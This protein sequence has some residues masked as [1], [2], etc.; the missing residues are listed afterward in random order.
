MIPFR[1]I[2]KTPRRVYYVRR[3]DGHDGIETGYVDRQALEETGVVV[4]RG[5]SVGEYDHC[6]FA[7]RARAEAFLDRH[8]PPRPAA[9]D[10]RQLRREMAD[11]HPDRGGTAEEFM[12]ARERYERAQWRAT[13]GRQQA[14]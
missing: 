11:A 2:R 7:N 5:V 12:A 8:R 3:E 6:L 10:L 4:N 1:I 13:T 14:G 9:A